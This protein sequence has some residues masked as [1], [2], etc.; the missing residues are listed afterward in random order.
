[1]VVH[2]QLVELNGDDCAVKMT[3]DLHEENTHLASRLWINMVL[4]R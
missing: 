1:M 3:N 4:I 2:L